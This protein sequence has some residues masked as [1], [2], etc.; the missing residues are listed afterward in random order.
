[1]ANPSV[2]QPALD[3][4][5]QTKTDD[6]APL[7]PS[8][9]LDL[10]ITLTLYSWPALSLAVESSWGGPT[11]SDKRDWFCGAIADLFTSRPETDAADLEDV[12]I[13]VMN[14][15]FEVAVDD[16]SA[17]DIA[18]RICELKSEIE[19]GDHSRVQKMWEEFKTKSQRAGGDPASLF[20]KVEAR[21]ED[22]ETDD[23]EDDG[24]E[25]DVDMEDAPATNARPP[26]Q[27][28]EPEVDEDGFTKV[29]SRKKR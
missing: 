6:N 26:R 27:R 3:N 15:E 22:Q 17:G 19:K 28:E 21:D 16:D 2:E 20:K 8:A 24:G 14:D 9:Q 29:A 11:S 1:M 4:Q 18:D 23:E 12:L 10:A 13:Q 5:Q 7:S 25:S